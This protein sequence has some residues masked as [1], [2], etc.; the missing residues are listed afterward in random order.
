VTHIIFA[1]ALWQQTTTRVYGLEGPEVATVRSDESTR[2]TVRNLDGREVPVE[3][4]DEKVVSDAPGLRVVERTV[5]RYDPNGRPG[6]G[7]KIRIETRSGPNNSTE[8]VTTTWRGDINGNLHIAERSLAVTR[9][10]GTG[11]TDTTV[12]MERPA[13]DGRLELYER[14]EA[15]RRSPASDRIAESVRTERRDLNG[16]WVDVLRTTSEQTH[17]G[18]VIEEKREEY[19]AATTG[20]M[21]L[22]RQT[23]SRTTGSRT[24]SSITETDVF[25]PALA[26]RVSAAGGPLRLTRREITEH[27]RTAAGAVETVSVRFTDPSSPDRLLPPRKV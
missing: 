15:I 10:S 4:A 13:S 14:K 1:L 16:R 18:P 24:G 11:N 8:V 9:Q 19:E 6:P 12:S 27:S 22:V 23:V 25:E 17:A 26:G 2:Q 5:R 7:E 21:R 20:Q 3:T